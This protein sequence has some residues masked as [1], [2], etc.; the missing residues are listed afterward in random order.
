MRYGGRPPLTAV[1]QLINFR[2]SQISRG[3]GSVR[4][5]QLTWQFTAQP[6]PLSRVYSVLIEYQQ[7]DV[8]RVYIRD[9][10]ISALADGRKL[11]HV[12]K[13][14]PPQLCLYLPGT[15]EWL[16][17][18]RISETIVPWTFL[19]LWYFE[20]WLASGIWKGCGVHPSS[21]RSK[22]KYRRQ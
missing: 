6:D 3:A 19:W 12:Y 11:P 5:G 14:N 18:K 20:E 22:R 8:P 10:D 21:R 9:P 13:Q 16:P 4:F 17:S 2:A 7:G 1:P 15:G